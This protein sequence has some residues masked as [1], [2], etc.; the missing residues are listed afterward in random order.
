MEAQTTLVKHRR[1]CFHA[2]LHQFDCMALDVS[3]GHKHVPVLII[4]LLDD[5]FVWRRYQE[6]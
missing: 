2:L 5:Q 1:P 3:V 6:L 4:D